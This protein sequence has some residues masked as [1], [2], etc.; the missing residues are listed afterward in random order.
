MVGLARLLAIDPD[1]PKALLQ[2]QECGHHVRPISTGI[3]AIDRM[4]LM[5]ILWYS[6]Q[7]KRIARAVTLAPGKA[8]FGHFWRRC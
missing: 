2:G 1:S 6:R 4:G 7:L 3:K 5:E 8:A